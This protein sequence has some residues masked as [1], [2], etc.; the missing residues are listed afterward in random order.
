VNEWRSGRTVTVTPQIA[1]TLTWS[2]VAKILGIV[3]ALLVAGYGVQALRASWVGIS[4][5]FALQATPV[6]TA[7]IEAARATFAALLFLPLIVVVRGAPRS[8]TIRYA[9]RAMDVI[10]GAYIGLVAVQVSFGAVWKPGAGHIAQVVFVA[11]I[12]S[13][14]LVAPVHVIQR[15]VEGTRTGFL[16]AV[17]TVTAVV[18]AASGVV[19]L[20][21]AHA[22]ETPA[23]PLG[24]VTI[25][26]FV[27]VT[28]LAIAV[29]YLG[30]TRGFT[31]A[32]TSGRPF[33]LRNLMRLDRTG[34][35]PWARLGSK[36]ISPVGNALAYI[37]GFIRRHRWPQ[38]SRR[39]RAGSRGRRAARKALVWVGTHTRGPVQAC[40]LALVVSVGFAALFLPILP[41]LVVAVP[42]GLY[43]ATVG[44]R[45]GAFI[46]TTLPWTSLP[47]WT[48][49][50]SVL[51]ALAAGTVVAAAP[52]GLGAYWRPWPIVRATPGLRPLL[53]ACAARRDA[54]IVVGPVT[55]VAHVAP[56]RELDPASGVRVVDV[57]RSCPPAAVPVAVLGAAM[58]TAEIRLIAH[59]SV[60]N[61]VS[62]V[63]FGTLIGVPTELGQLLSR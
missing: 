5:P 47:S 34:S 50:S 51:L 26:G 38:R 9:S 18:L 20:A 30:T 23:D 52:L 32:M 44:G 14:L 53:P 46:S 15:G 29:A 28:T 49:P 62:S 31:Q 55:D 3:P 16:S 1:S 2:A 37:A 39:V 59:P 24:A 4:I 6:T 21:E 19:A 10:I 22:E 58:P 40:G 48:R 7:G 57:D 63:F 12:G 36:L 54:L 45:S 17:F 25:F 33:A 61:A 13:A 56:A 41:F 8:A 11:T 60:G 42:I 27:L 43:A 35:R